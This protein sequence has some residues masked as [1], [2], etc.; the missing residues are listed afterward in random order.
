MKRTTTIKNLTLFSMG[1]GGGALWSP[2]GFSYAASSTRCHGNPIV[3]TFGS[4]KENG[5]KSQN[6]T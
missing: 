1:G 4:F 3:K 5:Q 2:K 6:S